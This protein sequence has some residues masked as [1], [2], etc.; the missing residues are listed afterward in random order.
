MP[1]RAVRFAFL[2]ALT[3]SLAGCGTIVNTTNVDPQTGGQRLIY[4]GVRWDL[5]HG[6]GAAAEPYPY[7]SLS[8]NV[9]RNVAYGVDVL[10]SAIGDT[11][12]LPLTAFNGR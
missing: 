8:E 12:T 3:A 2:S 10:L 4:G 11:F 5:E 9:P 7:S 1:L 6:W